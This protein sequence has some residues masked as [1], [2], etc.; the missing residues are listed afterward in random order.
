MTHEQADRRTENQDQTLCLVV[1]VS[2]KNGTTYE[3]VPTEDSWETRDA[4][5]TG[6]DANC[7][8]IVHISII[9]P[10]GHLSAD[11]YHWPSIK[12]AE[13]SNDTH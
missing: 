10:D 2:A 3:N 8:D 1:P 12:L 11:W 7:G 5:V 4:I 9:H 13:E 6:I